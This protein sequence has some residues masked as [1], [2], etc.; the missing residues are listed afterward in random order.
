M[1]GFNLLTFDLRNAVVQYI[2]NRSGMRHLKHLIALST[3]LVV[4]DADI[5]Q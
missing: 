1:T 4:C 2:T 3:Q 5:A